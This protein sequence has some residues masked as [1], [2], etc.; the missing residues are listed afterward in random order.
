VDKLRSITELKWSYK[1]LTIFKGTLESGVCRYPITEYI[2]FLFYEVTICRFIKGDV[3]KGFFYLQNRTLLCHVV[4]I[5]SVN[6]YFSFSPG[7][8]DPLF[9]TGIYES[10]S[11]PTIAWQT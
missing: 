4:L 8:K 10:A 6:D 2:T 5:F 3:T 7:E 11:P 1:Y 9:L